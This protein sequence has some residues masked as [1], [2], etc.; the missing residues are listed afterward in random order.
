MVKTRKMCID[1]K[2]SQKQKNDKITKNKSI[3]KKNQIPGSSIDELLKLCKP[4]SICLT[5]CDSKQGKF[6]LE[7]RSI[8]S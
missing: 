3:K 8:K 2:K 1:L 4:F 6:Y 7:C 5:R